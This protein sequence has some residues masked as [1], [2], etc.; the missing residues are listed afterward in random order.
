MREEKLFRTIAAA[1]MVAA[2]S[3]SGYHRH[4]AERASEEKSSP[5]ALKE[6]GL[7]T[8][9]TL[10]SLGLVLVLSVVAY[11]LNPRWMKWSSL[12]VPPWLRWSGAGLGTATLPLS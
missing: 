9:I 1:L 2:A 8:A 6:E 12:E 5:S 7:P 4:K 10:R 3:V 11:I